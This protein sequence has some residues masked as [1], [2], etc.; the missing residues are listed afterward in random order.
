[1]HCLSPT[2]VVGL[3]FCICMCQ[4]VQRL[5]CISMLGPGIALSFVPDVAC[6]Y[7]LDRIFLKPLLVAFGSLDSDD[8]PSSSKLSP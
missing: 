8:D 7:S 2:S 3:R 1:M 5:L 4:T 6:G